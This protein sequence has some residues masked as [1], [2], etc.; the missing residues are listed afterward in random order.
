MAD[1]SIYIQTEIDDKSAVKQLQ[2]LNRQINKLENDIAKAT[3]SRLPLTEQLRDAQQAAIATGNEV[4]RLKANL[5]A[6]LRATSINGNVDA[7]T[8]A[9]ELERQQQLKAELA[10]QEKLLASQEKEAQKLE[11]ADARL[12]EKTQQMTSELE[13]AK[14][15]AG[16]LTWRASKTENVEKLKGAFE[17]VKKSIQGGVKKLLL[18]GFAIRST[19]FLVR[20]LRTYLKEAITTFSESDPET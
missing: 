11:A 16:E 2:S 5:A 8:F 18:W 14:T 15:A 7:N 3:N 6:S 12:V 10:E 9:V 20:K 17:N 19:Y 4:D 1:G 13:Q